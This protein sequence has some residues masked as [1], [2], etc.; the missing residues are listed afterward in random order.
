MPVYDTQCGAKLFRADEMPAGL[1]DEP[2]LTRWLFDVEVLA[3]LRRRA[4]DGKGPTAES[5]VVE[6]PL[7]RW[8]DVPG[9]KVRALDFFRALLGLRR[10]R[11]HYGI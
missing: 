3:R 6:V 10:I 11:R 1:L 9:S 5:L 2:F 7:R 4:L 8:T